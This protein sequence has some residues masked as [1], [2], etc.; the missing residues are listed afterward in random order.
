[1]AGQ[2]KGLL[3]NVSGVVQGVNFRWFVQR[4]AQNLGLKGYVKNLYDG[5]V[6]AYAEGEKGILNAFYEE[7]KIG[8]RSAHVSGVRVDWQEYTGEF[9][10]FRIEL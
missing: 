1:M 7:V 9:K 5:S 8:P 4:V 10:D 2:L 6:E 3:L